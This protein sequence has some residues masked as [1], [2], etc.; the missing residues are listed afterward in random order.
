MNKNLNK[1]AVVGMACRYPGADN[2][3]EFWNNILEGRETIKR[4]SDEE[5]SKFEHRFD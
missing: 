3:D 4:F 2:I 1:I 5:L